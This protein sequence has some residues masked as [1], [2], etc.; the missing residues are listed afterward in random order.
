MRR[1]VGRSLEMCLA[2]L[3]EMLVV[4]SGVEPMKIAFLC[5]SGM[6]GSGILACDLAC[7][8]ANKGHQ[9]HLIAKERPFRLTGGCAN[10]NFH[11]LESLC[12]QQFSE[13]GALI[14][15]AGQLRRLHSRFHFDLIHCH[16]LMPFAFAAYLF[17]LSHPLAPPVITTLHGSDITVLGRQRNLSALIDH[18]LRASPHLTSVSQAL[19]AQTQSM[20]NLQRDIKVI[21]NFL[22]SGERLV[23]EHEK[24]QIR[25]Q[26]GVA[27][28]EFLLVHASNFR[29]I[30]NLKDVV[31]A[32]AMVAQ[33]IPARLLLIGDGP[34]YPAAQRQVRAAG[35]G[36]RVIFAG[37]MSYTQRLMGACDVNL[38]LS[39]QESFGLV[40]LEGFINGVPAIATNVGGIPEVM[41]HG[42]EGFLCDLHAPRQVAERV[43]ALAADKQ[44]HALMQAAARKRLR[45]FER[46]GQIQ[47]YEDF[48]RH[49]CF[50]EKNIKREGRG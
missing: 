32:F 27:S 13:Q 4:K 3:T 5:H 34:E 37:A 40:L 33:R 47:E 45:R 6:G 23:T 22:P 19:A 20:F 25:R 44:L 35:L 15:T 18:V 17:R 9:I 36:E 48:Y 41:R 39:S 31:A 1:R 30:K 12:C 2:G 49:V 7:A 38:L 11:S 8:L 16:Y 50:V 26:L 24:Q 29:A 10:L 46:A 43:L 42:K 14:S 21:Y 28:E